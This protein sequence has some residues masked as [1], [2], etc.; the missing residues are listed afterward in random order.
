MLSILIILLLVV[1]ITLFSAFMCHHNTFLIYGSI[2]EASQ[3]KWEIV[4]HASIITS[5]IVAT[6]FGIA[7]YST[8]KAYS[9]GTVAFC[10]NYSGIFLQSPDIIYWN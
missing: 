8:F 4:T 9:Q 2:E 6:L 7:G 5:L 10:S 1:I 3:K